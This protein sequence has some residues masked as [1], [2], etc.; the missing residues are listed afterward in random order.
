MNKIADNFTRIAGNLTVCH[1]IATVTATAARRRKDTGRRAGRHAD[2]KNQA[3]DIA[4]SRR[5]LRA[6][7]AIKPRP[8][9]NIAQVAGSG[10]GDNRKAW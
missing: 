10:A 6:F 4:A 7:Q 8:S 9:S 5:V 3:A 2:R 1:A